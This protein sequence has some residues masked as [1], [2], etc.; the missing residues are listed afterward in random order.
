MVF[1]RRKRMFRR[2]PYV[3]KSV[4]ASGANMYR[5]QKQVKSLVKKEKLNH[6]Y[7]NFNQY[8]SGGAIIPYNYY[9]LSDFNS[10]SA[11]PIFGTGGND[12]EGNQIKHLSMGMHIECNLE[13]IGGVSEEGTIQFS[14]FIVSLKDEANNGVLFNANTGQ[15]LLNPG[16]DYVYNLVGGGAGGMVMLN[17]KKFNI[18]KRKYFT[19]SNHE[20]ALSSPSAQTQYGTNHRW[21]WK[22]RVNKVIRNPAGDWSALHSALDPSKNYYLLIFN[23]NA[24]IDLESPQIQYNIV[25]TFQTL[26]Q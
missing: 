19:L 24:T 5:L 21:Y 9:N 10:M 3:K 26:G 4:R 22:Q 12:L 16:T 18:H 6:Q 13:N 8:G 1:Y 23:D 2:R 7:L 20:T 11:F 25:H 14:C 17:K 15:L